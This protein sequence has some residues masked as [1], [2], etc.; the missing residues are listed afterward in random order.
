M[1]R[2]RRARDQEVGGEDQKDES[3]QNFLKATRLSED[4]LK[5]LYNEEADNAE[6]GEEAGG[7]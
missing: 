6:K 1:D 7:V 5:D 3:I 4:V 2:A